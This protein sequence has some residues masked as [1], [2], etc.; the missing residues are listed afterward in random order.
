MDV[1]EGI[2]TIVEV[3]TVGVVLYLFMQYRSDK[4]EQDK[5]YQQ[6][7]DKK[8]E[9]TVLLNRDLLDAYKENTKANTVQAEALKTLST[10]VQENTRVMATFTERFSNAINNR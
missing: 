9:N 7:I 8:D 2:K 5:T 10:N 1:F 4:K 6:T 3:G